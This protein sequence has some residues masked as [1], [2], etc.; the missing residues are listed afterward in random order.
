MIKA[1]DIKDLREQT[2]AG[3]MDCKKALEECAGDMARAMDYLREKGIAKAAKKA[4]R[5]AAEGLAVVK[6]S[7]NKAIVVE[8]N[9]ETDFV[10][11]N[12]EFQALVNSIGE[13]VLKSTAHDVSEALNLTTDEG[14]LNDLIINKT[15]KIGEK[16]SFRRFDILEKTDSQVF[17]AY[18]HMGGKIV[19]L[20]VLENASLDLAKDIAMHIAAMNPLYISS[21][22]VK[23]D[24]IDREREVLTE[25]AHNE[26]LD[27]A[28]I[29][30]IVEGRLKK[31]YEENCLLNQNFIKENKMSV[32]NYLKNNKASL[33][34][35]I[36]YSVG[37]GIEKKNEDFASEVMKQING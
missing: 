5:I 14:T 35:M 13:V 28:R 22:D 34:S 30:M 11:K 1:S 12:E 4:S 16:L 8:V 23:Q 37:E 18:S 6:T 24:I 26:G 3:M 2:G 19:S 17:G 25:Q 9:S 33:I 20:C 36:R 21:S 31:F 15:A 32:D 27:S 29:P 10:A 7:G